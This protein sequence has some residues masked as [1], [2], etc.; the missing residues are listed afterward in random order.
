[1]HESLIISKDLKNILE[2]LIHTIIK[3]IA[4]TS[5]KPTIVIQK[6]F[7]SLKKNHPIYFKLGYYFKLMIQRINV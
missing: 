4:K 6:V 5:V 3:I 7:N 1:M 2:I